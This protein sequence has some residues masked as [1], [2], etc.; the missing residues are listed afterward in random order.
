L[1]NQA[2]NW[3]KNKTWSSVTNEYLKLYKW[4]VFLR[5]VSKK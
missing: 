1:V 3:V 2:N 4:R 5:S